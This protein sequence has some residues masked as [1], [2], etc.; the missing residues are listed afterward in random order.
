MRKLHLDRITNSISALGF[1]GYNTSGHIVM[2][3]NVN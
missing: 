2:Q 3:S 1:T